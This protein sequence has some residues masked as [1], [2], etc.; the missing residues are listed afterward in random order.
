MPKSSMVV[1]LM[2]FHPQKFVFHIEDN[3]WFKCGGGKSKFFKL[4]LLFCYFNLSRNY[5]SSKI[6]VFNC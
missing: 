1:P 4:T 6:V 5:N 3:A 2:I